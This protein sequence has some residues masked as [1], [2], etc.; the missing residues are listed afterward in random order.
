MV[1]A[2][3][4][5]ASEIEIFTLGRASGIGFDA[6]A[7]KKGIFTGQYSGHLGEPIFSTESVVFCPSRQTEIGHSLPVVTMECVGRFHANNW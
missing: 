7:C 2:L 4:K 3:E 1:C 6:A 5:Y